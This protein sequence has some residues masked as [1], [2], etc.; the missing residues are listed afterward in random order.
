MPSL[1]QLRTGLVLNV[2]SGADP[3][4]LP[5]GSCAA[6]RFKN[7][8]LTAAHCI[9]EGWTPYVQVMGPSRAA[10]PVAGFAVHESADLA[11]L[12]APEAMIHGSPFVGVA[13]MLYEGGGY[14]GFGYPVEGAPNDHPV[15]RT[16]RGYVQREMPYQAADGRSYFALEMSAPAPGGASG[17]VLA[18][19]DEP[20]RAAAV[21]AVNHDSWMTVERLEE[22]EEGGRSTRVEVRRVLSFGIAVALYGREGWLDEVITDLTSA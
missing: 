8:F 21:V 10:A 17:T 4:V 15:G 18:Y 2:E 3:R 19:D 1:A 22:L 12:F 13:S 14:R 16:L 6:Y 11:V 20:D 5:G 9:W 7:V